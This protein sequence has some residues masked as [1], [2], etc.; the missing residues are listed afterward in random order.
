MG[1]YRYM[2]S[3]CPDLS[4]RR[5]PRRRSF[6]SIQLNQIT[7]STGSGSVS[8]NV[9]INCQTSR[10]GNIRYCHPELTC[11]P[12]H[13]VQTY[14]GGIRVMYRI[15]PPGLFA[16]RNRFNAVNGLAVRSK[17]LTDAAQP[18]R[19]LYLDVTH[20]GRPYIEEEIAVAT[21]A[22]YQETNELMGRF[23]VVVVGITTPCF[24]NRQT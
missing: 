19:L 11:R 12:V 1:R 20:R 15:P 13:N 16:I 21:D 5:K 6:S 3:I 17:P 24:V 4:S 10:C 23:M 2:F 8:G 9:K 18:V 14:P 7:V 22:F